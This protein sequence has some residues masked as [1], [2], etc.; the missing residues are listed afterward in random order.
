[1]FVS[2]ALAVLASLNLPSAFGQSPEVSAEWALFNQILMIGIA[3]GLVVF[4]IMF[5]VIVR[6]RERPEQRSAT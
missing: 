4:G 2:T 6:Y 5:Y 3:T 1:M